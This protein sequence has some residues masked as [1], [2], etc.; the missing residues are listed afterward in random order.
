M[1]VETVAL[2]TRRVVMSGALGLTLAGCQ[3][4]TSLA[5]YPSAAAAAAAPTGVDIGNRFSNLALLRPDGTPTTLAD[6]RGK[7]AFL[8]FWGSWCP[9][10]IREFPLLQGLYTGL[11]DDPRIAF[12]FINF[13]EPHAKSL[14]WMQARGFTMPLYDSM[15]PA[16]GQPRVYQ[17]AGGRQVP[18]ASIGI[19]YYPSTVLLDRN[20]LVAARWLSTNNYVPNIDW[21]GMRPA[22]LHMAENSAPFRA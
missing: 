14:A 17:L 2:P 22:L 9:P 15:F 12:V 8:H 11:G 1:Q 13:G 10:C 6:M 16:S 7:I 20:G 18:S 3:S 5:P 21:P 19:N 4:A